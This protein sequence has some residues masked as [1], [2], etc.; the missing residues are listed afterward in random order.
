MGE[1][2]PQS[3]QQ[4]V[5][6]FLR[7][8]VENRFLVQHLC[9][10]VEQLGNVDIALHTSQPLGHGFGELLWVLGLQPVQHVRDVERTGLIPPGVRG[11]RV[12]EPPGFTEVADNG[13]LER[14]LHSGLNPHILN[15]L[16]TCDDLSDENRTTLKEKITEFGGLGDEG[17]DFLI[18][19]GESP[20]DLFLS[21]LV[22]Y[23]EFEI[24][25]HRHSH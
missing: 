5:L 7:P 10:P 14:L 16:P 11:V 24:G 17:V 19:T 1:P 6:D 23:W 25:N 21:A 22:R 9:Q 20:A 2:A 4:A 8:R 18:Q 15:L 12:V 13:V 3:A